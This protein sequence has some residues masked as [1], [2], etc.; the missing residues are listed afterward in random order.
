MRI[1]CVQADV[2][3]RDPQANLSKAVAK[4]EELAANSVDLAV[5]PEAY[6]TGYCVDSQSEADTLGIERDAIEPMQSACNRLGIL[7]VV[8][9]AE[10]CGSHNFNGAALLEPG[11]EPRFYRKVH[12]PHLG[13]D[14]FVRAGDELNDFDTKLGR[15]GILICY[16]LRPPEAS[17]ALALAG[18][19]LIVLPTNWPKG[20]ETSAE[21]IAIARAAENGVFVATCDRVGKENGFEFIGLSKIIDPSGHVLAAAGAGEETIWADVDLAAARNKRV[22]NIP[23]KYEIDVMACRRP[24]LYGALQDR[25]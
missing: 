6:L 2:S 4:L 7:A 17:R 20:A 3:F 25:Q 19:E 18:A 5:F 11:R 22:V 24:E 1:A 9:F 8:G 14:R 12:L 23:G 21:H 10:R 15:I 16:D 13:L